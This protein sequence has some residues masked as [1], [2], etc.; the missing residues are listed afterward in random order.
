MT[1]RL[2]PSSQGRWSLPAYLGFGRQCECMPRGRRRKMTSW[3]PALSTLNTQKSK[4]WCDELQELII[5]NLRIYFIQTRDKSSCC[6]KYS[7][8]LSVL[9]SRRW[10]W[11]WWCRRTSSMYADNLLVGSRYVRSLRAV[12]LR[13]SSFVSYIDLFLR[14]VLICSCVLLLFL[15]SCLRNWF[16]AG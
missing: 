1:T 11:W 15:S 6:H 3:T 7:L 16:S 5:Y 10:I 14:L 2:A 12:E 9:F 13:A 4:D 8:C